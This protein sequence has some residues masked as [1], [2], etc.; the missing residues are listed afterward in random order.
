MED[1]KE[2]KLTNLFNTKNNGAEHGQK[3][4]VCIKSP[5]WIVT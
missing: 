3:S 5:S 1:C 4:P 2:R